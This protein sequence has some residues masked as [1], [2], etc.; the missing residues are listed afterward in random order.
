MRN[1]PK[2]VKN[3]DYIG[4]KLH[5]NTLSQEHIR[6]QHEKVIFST[7]TDKTCKYFRIS[8]SNKINIENYQILIAF[9]RI[10]AGTFSD[11]EIV[12]KMKLDRL[13]FVRMIYETF[14]N[15]NQSSI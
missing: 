1:V 8:D 2:K 7:D 12:N 11:N 6:V 14:L 4:N 9:K 5:C 10:G 13:I 15:K 3:F